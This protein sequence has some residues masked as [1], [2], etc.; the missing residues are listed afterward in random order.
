M[1]LASIRLVAVLTGLL[2]GL[3]GAL[4]SV[5]PAAADE[6]WGPFRGQ[7]V[8]LETGEPIAGAVMLA[9]W[10]EVIAT[11]VEGKSR[12]YDALEAVTGADGRFEIPR[13]RVPF[14][15]LGVQPPSFRLFAPGYKPHTDVVTPPGG[16]LFVDPTVVKMRRLETH[17]ELMDKSRSRP[18]LVPPEKM[19]EFTRAVNIERA[20]L[21]LD[22]IDP[23]GGL[24]K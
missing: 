15:K 10:W 1:P 24:P 14:W 9:V 13:L 16:K 17:A 6:K 3:A 5:S 4:A 11:P 20:R 12:F 23:F 19:R 2:L 18:A 8:D 22:P 7:V 21:G